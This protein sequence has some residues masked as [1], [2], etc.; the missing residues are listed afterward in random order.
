LKKLLPRLAL[1][2]LSI[3]LALVLAEIGLRLWFRAHGGDQ[4]FHAALVRARGASTR[5]AFNLMQLVQAS[6]VPD[7][8]YELRP[9]LAGT[10]RG[11]SVRTTAN[12]LRGDRDVTPEKPVRTVRI[13]GLGDSNTFGWGVGEGEPYLEIV[14]RELDASAAAQSG[15]RFEVLNF[16]VPGYNTTMEVATY[17][18]R[19][20]RLAPDLVI[21]HFIGNDLGL[22]H[23]MQP[24]ETLRTTSHVYLWDLLH[25]RFG[26]MQDEVDPDLLA[27]DRSGLDPE[28]RRQV[29]SQYQHM[30]GQDAYRRAMARLAALTR[31][32][33]IPVIVMALG[34]VSGEGSLAHQA[35]DANGFRFLDASPHFYRYLIDH[36]IGTEK[37]DWQRTFRIPH[38]GHPNRLAHRLYAEVLMED[39]AHGPLLK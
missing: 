10:F 34:D 33:G 37:A 23:F 15:R 36:G 9:G 18:H 19:A 39:L 20:A 11:Q 6:P 8:V 14:Q 30:L 4:D 35:A 38:D 3:V 21:I 22:P 24:P 7:I 28:A 12:G 26:S 13:V 1:L 25:A 16:G 17:E 2:A 31:P 27:H 32:R 29:R 5:G